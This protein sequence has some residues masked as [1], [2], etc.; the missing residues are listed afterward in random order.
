MDSLP[1]AWR[2]NSSEIESDFRAGE[3][4]S[5][6][7]MTQRDSE[8]IDL[9]RTNS[10]SSLIRGDRTPVNILCLGD[11][12]QVPDESFV[13]QAKFIEISRMQHV[14]IMQD[15]FAFAVPPGIGDLLDLIFAVLPREPDR[16]DLV[17]GKYRANPDA[18]IDRFYHKYLQK[19]LSVTV[20]MPEDFSTCEKRPLLYRLF[21]FPD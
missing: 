15:R 17:A 1:P 21:V 10:D 8:P 9:K 19:Q 16:I 11:F 18:F 6:F 20:T 7:G 3:I 5:F 13:V 2:E 4:D 12:Q 14:E